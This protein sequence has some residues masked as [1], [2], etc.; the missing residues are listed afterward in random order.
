MSIS[1]PE[2]DVM[3]KGRVVVA[4]NPARQVT[5]EERVD[6][7]TAHRGMSLD[8]RGRQARQRGR[9]AANCSGM[10]ITLRHHEQAMQRVDSREAW[11]L[12]D[13]AAASG[14][15]RP[16]TCGDEALRLMSTFVEQR[17]R[18]SSDEP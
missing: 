18:N 1:R 11:S 12:S 3:A 16:I 13:A 2:V 17:E 8:C 5:A 10:S 4:S 15:A 6:L 14:C 9:A 7:L